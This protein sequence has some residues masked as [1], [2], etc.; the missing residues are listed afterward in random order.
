MSAGEGSGSGDPR[1]TGKAAVSKKDILS[2]AEA[3]LAALSLKPAEA[4]MASNAPAGTLGAPFTIQ[5]NAFGLKLKE[6]MTFWRYDVLIYAEV[7]GG[8]KTVFFTKKGREDYVIT[9]RNYKCKLVFDAVVKSYP[10]FFV[11]PDQLWYDGQ[12]VLVAGFDLYKNQERGQRKFEISGQDCGDLLSAI[13]VIIFDISPVADNQYISLNERL[14]RD[15]TANSD[16]TKNDQTIHRLLELVFSQVAVRNPQDFTNFENGKTFINEPWKYGFTERD[17]PE[18][19]GGKRLYPGIQKSVRFIEG[20]GGRGYNNPSLIIDAKKAAFHENITLIEK[21][22]ELINDDLQRKVSDIALRR[23][24][25][26][27]KDLWFYTKHTGYESDHQIAGISEHTAAETTFEGP[28]GRTISIVDYFQN[29]YNITIRYPNAPLVKVR[30]RG[31]TNSYPME[32]GCLR[33]MQRVTIAQ[34]TPDQIHRTTRSCAVPPGERQ[35]NIVRGARAVELFGSDDNSYV[36]SAGLYIYKEPVKVHGRLLPPPKIK[37]QNETAFVKEGKWRT[38]RGPLLVP[39]ECDVWAVYALVPT[40]EAGRFDERMLRN[41]AE[42][43]YREANSRGIKIGAPAEIKLLTSEKDLEDR[44]KTAA[45]CNCKFCLIVTADSITTAHKQIKL[46]ERELEMVT[47]DVKLSNA[48]KVVSERRV[49]TLENIILK[50]NLKLGG[51]NYEMDLDGIL[52]KEGTKDWIRPGR[53]FLGIGVSHPPPS[54]TYDPEKGAPSVIGYAANFKANRFDI[55]GDYLFQSSRREE[56][57]STMSEVVNNVLPKFAENHDKKFPRDLIIYRSGLSEGSFS[58]VLTHEI[59]LLRGTL[60]ALGAKN[61]KIVFIVAQKEHNVRLM[62][63]R[64]ERSRKPTD[65]NI[66]PGIVVDTE[67]THPSFKEFYLNSHITL[68]GSAR[69][70]RYTV[71]VDDL[72]LSMDELEGM[73]YVLTYG[74]QIVNLPTS[75][76]TPLYV[77]NRYAERGRNTYTAHAQSSGSS[78]SDSGASIDY[79]RL[80]H[81]LSYTHTKLAN[82]RVNA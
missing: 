67:L 76:P 14:L 55:V 21:A 38:P 45:N 57:L 39:A 79:G 36:Q 75:L 16:L 70:P 4:V 27:M 22:K 71:L 9:N 42:N 56:T 28:D 66:P 17:C 32:L 5:T 69:T 72:N 31:R 49:V 8:R 46:W 29:K 37:Y 52:P 20:P 48:V 64:I 50:S 34:Q 54:A 7:K 1:A 61:I 18:V 12:S 60:S 73:T 51:L 2:E 47:Q 19:G 25:H 81:R 82:V 58:T 33:P 44:M 6:P 63:D 15:C 10:D 65:Q 77:A 13:P 40:H 26:G 74:H 11:E 43:Y 78:S 62:L 41:F 53:L 24:H 30:E 80:A 59:P 35:D 23:L 68:Q 3:K